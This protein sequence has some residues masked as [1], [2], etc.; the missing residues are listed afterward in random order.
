MA[1]S[2]TTNPRRSDLLRMSRH[3]ESFRAIRDPQTGDIHAWP[4]NEARHV[5]V[6]NS[7]G[8]N[9]RMREDLQRNSFLF[10]RAQLEQAEGARD[11]AD[12]VKMIGS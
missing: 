12:L 1:F 9:F 10:S 6:A 8:L 7:L 11:L 3:T 4:A 5:D 2:L